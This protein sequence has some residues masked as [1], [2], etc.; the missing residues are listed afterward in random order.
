MK[1]FY[2][3]L[4]V[5]SSTIWLISIYL[6][7]NPISTQLPTCILQLIIFV[8]TIAVSGFVCFLLI[9]ISNTFE[10]DTLNNVASIELADTNFL[11]TYLG[12]FF[13]GLSICDWCVFVCVYIM[14]FVFL[15]KSGSQQFNPIF[16]LFNYH[17]YNIKTSNGVNIFLIAKGDIIRDPNIRTFLTLRRV[18]N[19]TYIDKGE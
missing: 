15:L 19:I 12:Y 10:A 9:K 17:F 2:K 3:F 8:I 6:I 7:S 4:S 13:V 18:N 1:K 5:L 11:P 14:I 16:L